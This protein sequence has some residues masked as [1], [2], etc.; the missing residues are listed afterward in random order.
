MKSSQLLSGVRA[1]ALVVWGFAL[2][3]A[4]ACGKDRPALDAPPVLIAGDD[5]GDAG[6]PVCGVQCSID[7]R[8]KLTVC[9]G[10]VTETV[11]CPPEMACGAGIC[12]EPCA[13]AAADHNSNGCD[14]YFQAPRYSSSN[15]RQS[16]Y[17]AYVVN[18]SNQDA[19]I[20]LEYQGQPIDISKSL[21]RT[22]PGDATLTAHTGPLAPGEGAILFVSDRDRTGEPYVPSTPFDPDISCPKGVVPATHVDVIPNGTGIGSSFRLTAGM[23][24]SLASI[25]PFGG[26]SSFVP[27]ATLHLPVATWEKQHILIN[28]WETGPTGRPAALIV[29]SEDDTEVT[30]L[31]RVDLQNGAGVVGGPA[32]VPV[33]FRLGKGQNLQLVQSRELTGSLVTSDKP[34]TTF[35]GH[36]CAEVP[37]GKAACDILTQQIPSLEQWGSEYVGVGYRPRLGNEHEPVGYR[38]VAAQDGTLLEYDPPQPPAGAPTALSRGQSKL[39]YAGTGDAFVVRTQDADHP[40]YVAAYMSGGGDANGAGDPEFVNVVAAGQYLRAYSFYADP[41]YAEASLVIVRAKAYGKF[42]DVWLECA[43]NLTDFRPIGTRGDYEFT[44]VDLSRNFGNGAS[45]DGGTCKAGMQRM[46]SEGP[47]S[48]TLWGWGMYASYAFASGTALRK[49]VTNPIIVF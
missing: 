3:N 34:T 13:A 28:G 26:A 20:S 9:D 11:M 10:E 8:S 25:Y 30:L 39:F 49:L 33:K 17:A 21:F 37:V 23:P 12:Q 45:F 35:A 36:Q 41:T 38:I 42:N 47:F 32:G 19:T 27:A 46:S 5:G 15:Y 14:F 6:G 31:P 18:T 43:G 1:G 48:A 4:L 29:A 22:T 7:G 44:R 16:C 2:A 24:V 40:I